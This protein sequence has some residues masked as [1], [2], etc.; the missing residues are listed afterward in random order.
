MLLREWLGEGANPGLTIGTVEGWFWENK[1]E[2]MR[3]MMS[4]GFVEEELEGFLLVVWEQWTTMSRLFRG[5]VTDPLKTPWM[6]S[7]I[8]L[9]FFLFQKECFSL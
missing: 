4:S 3:Y 9:F 2:E 8:F 7:K 6:K 1:T 5:R